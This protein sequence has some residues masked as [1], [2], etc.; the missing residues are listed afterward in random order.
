MVQLEKN[1]KFAEVYKIMK[2]ILKEDRSK[3]KKRVYMRRSF[4]KWDTFP[5]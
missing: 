1:K 2:E 4:I 5:K 3:F